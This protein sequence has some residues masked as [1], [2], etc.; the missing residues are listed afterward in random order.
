[1]Q[2]L[3]QLALPTTPAARSY[4]LLTFPFMRENLDTAESKSPVGEDEATTTQS[5]I[6]LY[7]I[8]R[9]NSN[10]FSVCFELTVL[11][12]CDDVEFLRR[13]EFFLLN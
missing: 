7:M 2:L 4:L 11:L 6:L 13:R 8:W 12:F 5:G 10:V 1:M 3:W 9:G